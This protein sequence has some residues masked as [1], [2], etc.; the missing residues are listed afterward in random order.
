[1]LTQSVRT[2]CY[3]HSVQAN[4]FDAGILEA[5]ETLLRNAKHGDDDSYL[6]APEE[7]Y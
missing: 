4:A 1:M 7:G 6:D 5:V 2:T 3:P